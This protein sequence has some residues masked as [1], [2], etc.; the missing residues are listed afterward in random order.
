MFV[1]YAARREVVSQR[2]D[3]ALAAMLLDLKRVY[4]A[5]RPALRRIYTQVIPGAITHC[6][7]TLGYEPVPGTTTWFNDLGPASI[8]GWLAGLG[9]R[10][11]LDAG[12]PLDVGDRRLTLDGVEV[13]LTRLEAQLLGY[14]REREGRAVTHEELLRDVWGH[15][16]TGGSNVV[17]VVVSGLRRKL[18]ARAAA[19]ETVRGVGY[20]LRG[21]A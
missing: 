16:W 7:M 1:P 14:L 4:V 12:E 2:F 18:G 9:A 3:A 11:L 15:E 13:E 20:R 21:L 19:L 5:M 8:D 17:Q 10:E 6:Y